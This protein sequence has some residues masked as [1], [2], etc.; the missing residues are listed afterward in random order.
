MPTRTI[1]LARWSLAGLAAFA[2]LILAGPGFAG[3]APGAA[4]SARPPGL[5]AADSAAVDTTRAPQP[6]PPPAPAPTPV[7][8]PAPIPPDTTQKPP[9][10][11][12]ADTSAHAAP[13]DTSAHAAPEVTAPAPAPAPAAPPLTPK[14]MRAAEKAKQREAKRAAYVAKH[15]PK[16]P[17]SLVPWQRGKLWVS[18]RAGGAKSTANG[19]ANGSFGGG[20]AISKMIFERVSVG[21]VGHGDLLGKFGGAAEIEYPITV[22]AL[23]HVGWKT[24]ARPYLG[25]GAGAF[26]H[27]FFRTGQDGSAVRGGFYYVGGVNAL[28]SPRAVLGVDG[29]LAIVS[30]KAADN[31]V[32]GHQQGRLVHLS[33]K[34]A[35]SLA[36]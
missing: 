25:L 32:F 7:P 27:K 22:E 1:S 29:R 2:T 23:Y 20:L 36:F 24:Q 28:V 12:P 13:A 3:Y 31:P 26:Y 30:G 17:D 14:Q 9:R 6:A 34:L 10:V 35:Y 11:A 8:L 21:L 16:P 19:A 5:A 15:P 4:A 18:L 33:L